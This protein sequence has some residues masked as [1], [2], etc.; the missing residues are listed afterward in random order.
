MLNK[1]KTK[2]R[3][4][5]RKSEMERELD[6]ELRYHIERQ[7]EQNIRLGMSPEE[8]RYAARKSFGG[9]EQAK[10]RSRDSRG[11][12]WVEELWQDL[13]YGMRMLMKKPGSALI[14]VI[15]LALGIGANTAIFSVVNA[16][17]LRPLP[18]PEP[19]RLV[20]VWNTAPQFG[21]SQAPI[22]YGTFIDISEQSQV[23]EQLGAW[24]LFDNN[25]N[26]SGGG[27]PELIS[28][29]HVT[30][31][32]FPILGVKPILG[33]T[34]LPV[35]DKTDRPSVVVVSQ[36]L[37]KRRFSSDPSVIGQELALD[38]RSY[39][40]IG[41]MPARFTLPATGKAPEA[42]LL[43]S[44][45]GFGWAKR[46]NRG[47]HDFGVIA[48]LKRGVN[49]LQAQVEMDTIAK[50]L[51]QTYPKNNTGFGIRIVPLHKQAIRDLDLALLILF[52]AV[53][54]VLLIACTNVANILL[55]RAS[56]RQKEIALRAVLGASRWRLIRQLLTESI[57][58]SMMGGALGVL[59]ALWG[60]GVIVAVPSGKPDPYTPYAIP[61]EHIGLNGQV[62]VFTFALSL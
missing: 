27:E 59:L 2:L 4:L 40:V 54:F 31:S 30:A 13:R 9:V 1:L 23:F 24:E 26:L 51:E 22:A 44:Q 37:W 19:N 52:G 50:R 16:V 7:T 10:E 17:L 42:W 58:L 56:S 8:A 5:L 47:S 21:Y 32:L 11:V 61:T 62:L 49:T 48:R 29:A 34:F 14:V 41:I 6:E 15:T 20:A 53:T 25:L 28:S 46:E 33:R 3:A 12:R 43:I 57:L 45:A 39:T 55:A 38:T 36:G 35:D 18:F 60:I